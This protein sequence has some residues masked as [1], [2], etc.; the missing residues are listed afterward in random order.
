MLLKNLIG[1]NLFDVY[2]GDGID[3]GYKSLAIALVLQDTE[4]TLEEKDINDVVDRVV[5]TLK[6][7]LDAS[8][9]D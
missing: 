2:Q 9:R 1:L 6:S 3:A 5:D 7:E 8:L 4:K